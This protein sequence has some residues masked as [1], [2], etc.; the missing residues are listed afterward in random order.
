[1]EIEAKF[2]EIDIN[3]LRKIIKE[4]GGKRVH[5]MMLYERYVFLLHGGEKGYIRTRKENGK[6]TITIK[7]YPKDSKYALENEIEV[8][9]TLEETRDFLL[10]SGYKMKA[11]HQT[12]REKWQINGC[13][14]IAIDTIPGIPTYVELECNNEKEIKR[15]AK[16]LNLDFAQAKFGAYGN[17]FV[18]YYGMVLDDI[19]DTIDNLTFKNIDKELKNYIK[20]NKDLLKKIKDTHLKLIIKNKIKL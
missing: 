3:K 8:K 9:S 12:L 2:L 13:P 4:K 7:K 1:M 6:V 10:A 15:V 20:K 18:D 19:N 14:E 11:Y 5:K 17:Q 16:L